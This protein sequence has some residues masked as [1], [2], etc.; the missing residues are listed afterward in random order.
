MDN[1]G[2]V[3]RMSVSGYRGR[4]LKPRQHQYVVSFS[5]T[6]YPHCF[7]RLIC[8]MSTRWGQPREVCSVPCASRSNITKNTRILFF[9]SLLNFSLKGSTALISALPNSQRST[10][11]HIL[12]RLRKRHS[13]PSLALKD[14]MPMW[15]TRL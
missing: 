3:V 7:S 6:H 5:K 10:L 9:I 2:H 15:R 14:F 1:I 13:Q 8:E 11:I 12:W 4:R